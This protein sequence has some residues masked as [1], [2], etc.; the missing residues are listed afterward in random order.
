VIRGN[1]C[2]GTS[3][4]KNRPQAFSMAVAKCRASSGLMLC[5]ARIRAACS[6]TAAE[7]GNTN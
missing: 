1:V 7:I 3:F 5:E 6:Q 4:V 2:H